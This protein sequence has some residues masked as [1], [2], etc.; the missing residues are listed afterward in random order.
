MARFL[1]RLASFSR[2]IVF[3]KRGTGMSDRAPDDRPVVARGQGQRH[4]HLDGHGGVGAGRDDGPLGDR[5]G[6]A[7]VRRDV[8]GE[9]E[10]G[11]CLW[12]V[13]RRG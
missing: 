8:N 5:R 9:N 7:P 3:D 12:L 11:G 1:R 10:S 4:G 13:R 6:G 2:L